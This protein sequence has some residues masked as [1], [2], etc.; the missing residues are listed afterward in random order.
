[1]SKNTHSEENLNE[2]M[3]AMKEFFTLLKHQAIVEIV[4][5]NIES[6]I[7]IHTM[8]VEACRLGI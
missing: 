8:T 6:C 5:F 1:M 3:K 4:S 2:G 7:E